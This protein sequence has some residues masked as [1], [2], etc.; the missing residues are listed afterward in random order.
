M[1]GYRSK[2]LSHARRGAST[3]E[4]ALVAPVFFMF[5][6]GSV[7]LGRGMLVQNVLTN[8]AREAA[9]VA[10]IDGTDQ[11]TVEQA[12]QDYAQAGSLTNATITTDPSNVSAA[13]PGQPI[14]VNVSINFADASWIPVPQFLGDIELTGTATMRR[15]GF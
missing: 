7:E 4:F 3:V 15:E 8:A 2:K 10:V 9:R 6:V 13:V 11:S 12:A 5:I 14:T 1:L